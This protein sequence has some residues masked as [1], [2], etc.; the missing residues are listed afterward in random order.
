MDDSVSA[1]DT[2]TEK[3]ILSNPKESRLGKTTI[4]IA[5]RVSTVR[6]MDK[7]LYMDGGK[8]VGFGTHEQLI[9]QCPDYKNMVELQKLEE[10]KEGM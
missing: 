8:V 10:E 4:L 3:V 5:H 7:V 1:V 2:D 6:N 9:E